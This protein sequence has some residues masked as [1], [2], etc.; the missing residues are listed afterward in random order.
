MSWFKYADN[1]EDQL[2]IIGGYIDEINYALDSYSPSETVRG[3]LEEQ[4]H[5]LETM[6]KEF[7]TYKENS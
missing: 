2:S 7:A 1:I 3:I 5:R 6:Y 4:K